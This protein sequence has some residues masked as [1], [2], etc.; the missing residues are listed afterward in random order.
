M[1]EIKD[2]SRYKNVFIGVP[3]PEYLHSEYDALLEKIEGLNLNLNISKTKY[4]HVT[5]MFI[6]DLDSWFLPQLLDSLKKN[7]EIIKGSK[8]TLKNI[9]CFDEKNPRVLFLEASCDKKMIEF[10]KALYKDFE[11]PLKI[12]KRKFIPH[13]TLARV[14]NKKGKQNLVDKNKSFLKDIKGVNWQFAIDKI[15]L[16]GRHSSNYQQTVLNEISL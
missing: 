16:V 8:I 3:L 15:F 14:K 5:V 13:L 7:K 4:P 6:G 10:R 2:K 1:P 9:S 11:P 12:S